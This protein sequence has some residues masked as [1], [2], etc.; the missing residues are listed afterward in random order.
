MTR[1][2]LSKK[3]IYQNFEITNENLETIITMFYYYT[4]ENFDYKYN[5]YH[6]QI[7]MV[8]LNGV[9][10]N[11]YF[12][13]NWL[14]PNDALSWLFKLYQAIYMKEQAGI[15]FILRHLDWLSVS[16]KLDP[17]ELDANTEPQGTLT[18]SYRLEHSVNLY[19]D[20]LK[21]LHDPTPAWNSRVLMDEA[22][23]LRLNND[24]EQIN[25]LLRDDVQQELLY[26]QYE[27]NQYRPPATRTKRL[28]RKPNR[29]G[30]G[31]HLINNFRDES[32]KLN[33]LL[34]I[35]NLNY[36]DNFFNLI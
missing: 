9:V 3:T 27:R 20:F 12:H 19:D 33:R 14:L 34:N 1:S 17:L 36:V 21:D 25:F 22:I 8:Q 26:N 11:Q 15:N 10:N 18:I 24:D 23:N 28:R 7:D 29:W 35:K 31:I 13:T 16:N 30:Y 6:N 32:I 2:K 5:Y 4:I